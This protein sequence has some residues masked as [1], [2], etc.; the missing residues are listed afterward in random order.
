MKPTW[1][2]LRD[3]ID[4]HPRVL[5]I[6]RLISKSAAHTF[7]QVKGGNADLLGDA[8]VTLSV[9]VSRDVTV[10]S[11][12]RLWSDIARHGGD[13]EVTLRDTAERHA[14]ITGD[15]ETVDTITG[16]PGFGRALEKVGW[17]HVDKE[18]ELLFFPNF[19]EYN[20]LRHRTG[21]DKQTKT[22][23]ART[24]E[25]RKRL[26]EA[27]SQGQDVTP[28]VTPP[29]TGHP[30]V[31]TPVTTPV[32]DPQIESKSESHYTTLPNAGACPEVAEMLA[33]AASY[34]AGDVTGNPI[35]PEICEAW[36]D[37]RLK[38]GW[39]TPVGDSLR[40]IEDWKADL[41]GFAR[42]WKKLEGKFSRPGGSQAPRNAPTGPVKL[43]TPKKGGW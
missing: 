26:K 13:A 43:T 9:T 39:Q 4:T 16:I 15:V 29:V 11:L 36:R 38:I 14:C 1:I 33:Y 23:A 42:Q 34:T 27:A 8:M 10:A 40:D 6:A 35:T 31:T 32:T 3:D 18:R 17:L 41:R 2:K 5:K 21:A 28:P 30:S 19:L 22:S 7:F 37:A 20:V 24:A 12:R 25:Y